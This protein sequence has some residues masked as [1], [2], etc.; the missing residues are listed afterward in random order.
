MRFDKRKSVLS[1]EALE[2]LPEFASLNPEQ[3]TLMLLLATGVPIVTAIE[4]TYTCKDSR[5]AKAFAYDIMKRP[6]LQ[7]VLNRMFGFKDDD[8]AAFVKKVDKLS[9]TKNVT[10]AAVQALFLYGIV[11]GFIDDKFALAEKGH[12]R[13]KQQ[14]ETAYL[15]QRLE[16]HG[17][18]MSKT[19]AD[20]G[21]DR[22]N[23]YKKLKKL[24]IPRRPA[25]NAGEL[26]N[27]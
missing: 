2:S 26:K 24:G 19:A 21:M 6:R 20:V 8:K 27:E 12:R 13:V 1:P 5:S 25:V 16:A 10:M 9:R 11:N 14:F 18:N 17:G 7:P 3:K 22:R 15:T 4:K 23:L